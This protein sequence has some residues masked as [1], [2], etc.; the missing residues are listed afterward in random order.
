[1]VHAFIVSLLRPK[2]VAQAAC[3]GVPPTCVR[4]CMLYYGET[5]MMQGCHTR[6][7]LQTAYKLLTPTNQVACQDVRPL[8][9]GRR[10]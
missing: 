9:P 8:Q 4:F 6:Q 7:R 2:R 5:S 1:M 10:A 3:P